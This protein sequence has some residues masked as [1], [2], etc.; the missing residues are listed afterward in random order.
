MQMEFQVTDEWLKQ[1]DEMRAKKWYQS[2]GWSVLI[3][4]D[5]VDLLMIAEMMD[6]EATLDDLIQRLKDNEK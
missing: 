1:Q 2:I 6:D 4:S 3:C 5:P